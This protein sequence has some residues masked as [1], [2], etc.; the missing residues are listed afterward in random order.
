MKQTKRDMEE[1]AVH[2]RSE[3]AVGEE[4]LLVQIL[5]NLV[6]MLEAGDRIKFSTQWTQEG[7]ISHPLVPFYL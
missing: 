4:K 6:L 1:N 5:Q 3:D 2:F 7:R